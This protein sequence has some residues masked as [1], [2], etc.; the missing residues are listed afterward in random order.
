[1]KI[2]I[3]GA[4]DVEI[5]K[6]N[7]LFNLKEIEKDVYFANYNNHELYV[8]KCGIGKV[9][10]AANCQHLIDKYNVNLIINTGCAGSLLEDVKVLDVVLASYVT[11]H[12]FTPV[13][14]MNYSVPDEGKPVSD[15]NYTSLA[16]E[17]IEGMNLNVFVEGICSGDCFVTNDKQR[18][19][20]RENT[21]CY[22]VDMESASI[23]HISRKNNVPFIIVRTISDFADGAVD[24]EEKAGHISSDI[25]KHIIERI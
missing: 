2:G 12:D 10:S 11:Y 20:I 17:V 3:I 21:K 5:A 4:M 1:M 25:V 7:E 9:N 24:F 15:I 8:T 6:F 23:G 13:R 22:A 16:K 18:D 19:E 14:I